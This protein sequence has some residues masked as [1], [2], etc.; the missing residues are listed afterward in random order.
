MNYITIFRVHAW[1]EGIARMA[2]QAR[3]C[4][5]GSEFLVTADETRGPLP[6]EGFTKLSHT[7]DFSAFGL[8]SQP[9]D[10]VLWWNGDYVQY[11][12]RAALPGRDYYVMLDYDTYL[13]CDIDA[14]VAR[15]AAESVDLVVHDFHKISE[16]SV[17]YPTARSM[18]A[19]PWWAF[20]PLD[21]RLRAGGRRNAVDASG[22]GRPPTTG[23]GHALAQ[24]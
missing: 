22:A 16:S 4:C 2:A 9:A 17:W 5:R 19:K 15:C 24:S 10:Q 3:D 23:S 11:A 13:A 20:P 6:I 12:V 14:M 8:P 21:C 18:T 1:D 7:D